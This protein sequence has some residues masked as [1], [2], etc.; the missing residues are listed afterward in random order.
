MDIVSCECGCEQSSECKCKKKDLYYFG[1]QSASFEDDDGE[2][3]LH[4]VDNFTIVCV[5]FEPKTLEPPL[6]HVAHTSEFDPR[7]CRLFVYAQ[8]PDPD[9]EV[10]LFSCKRNSLEY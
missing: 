3:Q 6:I 4:K 5:G 2:L 7:E 9:F 1:T 8:C 10:I